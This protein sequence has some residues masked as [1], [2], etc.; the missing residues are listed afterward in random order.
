MVMAVKW[1]SACRTSDFDDSQVLRFDSPSG[2]YAI[3]R[4]NNGEYFATAGY[5][6]HEQAH[7]SE[8]LVVDYEIE[9]PR[10]SGV[11]DYRTGEA[12]GAPACVDLRTFP[13]RV[14]N[15]LVLIAVD[16]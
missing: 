2:T 6:T 8:G 14:E 5:C 4:S 7:L 15:G 1:V 12:I 3:F 10:H 16:S 9:C 11:F 13:V